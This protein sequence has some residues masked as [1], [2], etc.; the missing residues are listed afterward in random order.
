MC[1][2]NIFLVRRTKRFE[3]FLNPTKF[4]KVSI[5]ARIWIAISEYGL[6]AALNIGQRSVSRF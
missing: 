2:L 1:F 4:F 6:L 5:I 3:Q